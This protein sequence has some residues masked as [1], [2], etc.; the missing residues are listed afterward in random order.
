MLSKVKGELLYL[1]VDLLRFWLLIGDRQSSKMLVLE[2]G[3]EGEVGLLNLVVDMW[4]FWLVIGD[5][6]SSKMLVWLVGQ[7]QCLQ[8]D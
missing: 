1:V 3:E 6:Q 5:R 7:E 8:E 2:G 4:R